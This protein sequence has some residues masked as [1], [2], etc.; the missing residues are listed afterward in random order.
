MSRVRLEFPTD[1]IL[2]LARWRNIEH[3]AFLRKVPGQL[4][5]FHVEETSKWKGYE[6]RNVP[7]P[8]D[9]IIAAVVRG[10]NVMVATGNLPL[11]VDDRVVIFADPDVV[12]KVETT[13]SEQE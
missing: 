7:M 9:A 11:E 10:R 5:E 12:D 13:V 4:L 8:Q 6:I 2:H 3:Y 1:A